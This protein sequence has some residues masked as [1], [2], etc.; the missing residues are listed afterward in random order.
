MANRVAHSGKRVAH[1]VDL[2][3]RGKM[4]AHGWNRVVHRVSLACRVKFIAR[5]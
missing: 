3:C 4:V 1:R 2:V 5:S